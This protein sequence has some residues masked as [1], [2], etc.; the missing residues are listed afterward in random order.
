MVMTLR[1]AL[2]YLKKIISW[3]I[4]SRSM[5]IAVR[6]LFLSLLVLYSSSFSLYSINH[7]V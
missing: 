6:E 2:G 5:A 4:T 3:F 7:F 1:M